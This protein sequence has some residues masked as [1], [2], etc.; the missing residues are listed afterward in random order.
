MVGAGPGGQ[1]AEVLALLRRVGVTPPE[2]AV[3][4]VPGR[5]EVAVLLRTAHE[6]E[7]GQT[8]LAGPGLAEEALGHAAYGGAGPVPYDGRGQLLAGVRLAAAG[9]AAARLAVALGALHDELAQGLYG[10]EEAVR[11]DA[12]QGDRV[13]ARHLADREAV[14]AGGQVPAGGCA[15]GP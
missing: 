9:P 7:L 13:P 3:R 15:Q 12:V 4:V 10:V 5:V 11:A 14:A 2:L 8:L 1:R 6:V